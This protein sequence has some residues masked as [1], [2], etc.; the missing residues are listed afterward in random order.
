M[1]SFA[2]HGF[3]EE[4]TQAPCSMLPGATTTKIGLA[5]DKDRRLVVRGT[6]Q[7][8][9]RFLPCP[10]IK[11]KCVEQRISQTG[12]FQSFEKLFGND[13]IGV[14]IGHVQGRCDP[15]NNN[16]LQNPRG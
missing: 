12:T 6:I 2:N 4:D 8:K 11:A 15:F 5:D 10:G 16:K 3:K 7:N 1:V 13:H 14:D 9:V